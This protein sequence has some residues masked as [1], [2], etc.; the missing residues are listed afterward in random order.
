MKKQLLFAALCLL[1]IG[2]VKAQLSLSPLNPPFG[3]TYDLFSISSAAGLS[4]PSKGPN[5]TWTYTINSLTPIASYEITDPAVV[6]SN[7]I[8][9]VPAT[10]FVVRLKIA[11]TLEQD[12]MDFYEN[13]GSTLIRIGQKGSNSNPPDLKNDTIFHNK[14]ELGKGTKNSSTER[15]YYAWGK[16]NINSMVYDSVAVIKQYFVGGADTAYYFYQ[17]KPHFHYVGIIVFTNAN[18]KGMQ[19]YKPSG[20]SSVNFSKKLNATVYPNPSNGKYQISLEKSES[21]K[22]ELFDL[23][24]KLIATGLT[25]DQIVHELDFSDL[26]RGFYTLKI[27]TNSGVSVQKVLKN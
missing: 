24:G 23:S 20:T 3:Y 18:M 16:L 17:T 9:V 6:P 1:G 26:L 8:S 4:V 21:L 13:T 25:E 5:Q 15:T 10:D 7:Y 27:E 14:M 11:P 2:S 12:P 22:Y 19:Y